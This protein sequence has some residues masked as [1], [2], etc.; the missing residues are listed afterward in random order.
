M[1]DVVVINRLRTYARFV[2]LEHT[3]FSLPLL[4]AGALLASG[5]LPSLKVIGLIF[6][7][8]FGA[9][10]AAFAINRIADRHFDKLNPRTAIR[11]LPKG[12]MTLAEGI[13]VGLFGTF[14]Y[15]LAA[16]WIAPICLLLSPLPLAAFALYPFMKRFTSLA[17]FGVG[18]ADAFA[19]LGGWMAVKQSLSNPWP[20]LL[21]G[22]FTFFW[23]SGFDIIYSTMDEA[24]DRS[25]GLHSLPARWGAPRALQISAALH[26]AAFGVLVFLY[27]M[28]FHSLAAL[29]T[30]FAIGALLF[31]EQ[32][33]SHDVDLAF[34]KINAVLG[35]GVLGFVALGMGVR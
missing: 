12:S 35:F 20:G 21:L 32:R 31:L 10:T 17:H 19:P 3:V 6:L 2:K 29:V 24:F 16:W 33:L 15:L 14:V 30:L 11:E 1:Y 27:A 25:Q 26:I 28:S 7:A 8:G 18:L 23:V 4:L 34:F 5:Q 22:L 13:G 9:R